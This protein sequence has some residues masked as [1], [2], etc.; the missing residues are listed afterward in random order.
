MDCLHYCHPGPIDSWVE[1]LY[2]MLKK[3]KLRRGRP[4]K[5]SEAG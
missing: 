2:N 3:L 4:A 5:T 1:L